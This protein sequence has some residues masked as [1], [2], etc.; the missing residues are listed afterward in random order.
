MT[1]LNVV[2][3]IIYYDNKILC[4]QKGITKS[5]YMNYK[6]EFPG[7]KVEDGET[8]V[9][10]LKRELHEELDMDVEVYENDYFL[11]SE[12]NYPDKKVLLHAYKCKALKKDFNMKE[13]ISYKWCDI[14]DLNLLDFA[15]ADIIIKNKLIEER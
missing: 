15:K 1:E 3:G 14:T 10:A 4:L 13:H 8:N 6:F 12:T 5:E 9:E 2:C 11:T 7:G